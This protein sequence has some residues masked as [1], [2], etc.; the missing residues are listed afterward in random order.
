MQS[1]IKKRILP[2]AH[3]IMW[4]LFFHF[5]ACLV[6]M[7]AAVI[8]LN[9]FA[10]KPFYISQTKSTLSD[11][12]ATINQVA[13]DEEK[14]QHIVAKLQNDRAFIVFVWDEDGMIYPKINN[15]HLQNIKNYRQFAEGTYE[16]RLIDDEPMYI[17]NGSSKAIRLKGKL[18]NGWSVYMRTSV[19]AIEESMGITNRFLLWSGLAV[20]VPG[21]ALV[22][23]SVQ[24]HTRPIRYLS[25][26]ADR[27]AQ[28]DF[29]G[30]YDGDTRDEVGALGQSI[31]TMSAALEQ[32]ITQLQED[33]RLKEEQ[34]NARQMFIANVSHELKTPIGLIATYAEGL[35]EDIAAG[36]E[37]R[38][39]Y[40]KVIQEETY[41]VSHLLKRM[42]SLL[43]LERD[44]KPEIEPFDVAE[45]CRNLVERSRIQFEKK[46]V[47]VE[48]TPEV[49]QTVYADPFLIEHALTNYLS[50]AVNHVPEGGRVT[51][52]MQTV[53]ADRLRVTVFNSGSSIPPEEMPHIW[54]NF[55]KV[56]KAHTREYGGS[57]L[58]LS[59]VAAVMK[60]HGMP[61]T[62]ENTGDGVAFS[63]ELK[64][65]A[66]ES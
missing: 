62:A 60:A 4:K 46:Q 30:H 24:R 64:T 41:R 44:I 23:F 40:C 21:I 43:Q 18:D 65:V 5:V 39:Y 14:L 27:V 6:V 36:G 9:T 63:I 45:L 56:D 12:F 49:P 47:S 34:N 42:L 26:L 25:A 3:S 13:H 37:N 1:R 53:A 38:E 28:L 17:F 50:N 7:V 61:Y 2:G 31:N 11:A 15:P 19:A 48:V 51:V 52:R 20:L 59:I 8:L 54:E 29:S 10:L 32:T 58:G 55:Y 33:V 35:E 22:L 16:L 66:D 57:G